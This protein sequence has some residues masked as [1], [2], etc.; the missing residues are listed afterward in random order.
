MRHYRFFC[1]LFLL[2]VCLFVSLF[3]CL[4][5]C[6]FFFAKWAYNPDCLELNMVL[7]QVIDQDFFSYFSLEFSP[8]LSSPC[9]TRRVHKS[10]QI[11]KINSK[12]RTILCRLH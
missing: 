3:V 4:L 2:F 9:L 11:D 1:F 6:A 10:E 12:E 7:T 5:V 8:F